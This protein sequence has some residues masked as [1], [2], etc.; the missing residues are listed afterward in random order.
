MLHTF[1]ASYY[2]GC[3]ILL[4]IMPNQSIPIH[5]EKNVSKFIATGQIMH[6]ISNAKISI[7]WW[8]TE[9]FDRFPRYFVHIYF[10]GCFVSLYLAV[11]FRS[12]GKWGRHHESYCYHNHHF[13]VIKLNSNVNPTSYRNTD[14]SCSVGCAETLWPI[15][16]M[17]VILRWSTIGLET[18]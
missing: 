9:V 7:T 8:S 10:V 5:R 14:A 11:S 3:I 12:A 16:Y 4:D 17:M 15:A 13:A 18:K 2:T 6:K 1:F